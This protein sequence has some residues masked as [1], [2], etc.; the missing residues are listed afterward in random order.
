MDKASCK[1]CGKTVHH[2]SD[3][4]L[5]GM[6][7]NPDFVAR[8]KAHGGWTHPGIKSDHAPVPHDDRTSEYDAAQW[9]LPSTFKP[10]GGALEHLSA[11]QLGR[12]K[13]KND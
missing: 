13:G 11:Q 2:V 10:Y 12:S 4:A 7:D 6:G 3:E 5:A 9:K 1:T 8:V